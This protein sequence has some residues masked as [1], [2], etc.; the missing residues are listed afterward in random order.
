[1]GPATG[2]LGLDV[3]LEKEE[4]G[5]KDPRPVNQG[6]QQM[7]DSYGADARTLQNFALRK[8]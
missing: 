7:I 2:L 1:M 6:Q 5:Q 4:D 3:Q 8:P